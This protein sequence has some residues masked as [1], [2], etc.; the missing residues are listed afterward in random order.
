MHSSLSFM[1]LI[2]TNLTTVLQSIIISMTKHVVEEAIAKTLQSADDV[3]DTLGV[4]D[5]GCGS[6]P[7]TLSVM[8]AI[9]KAV[10]TRCSEIGCRLPELRMSL[11][12]LPDNDFNSVFSVLEPGFYR[13]MMVEK[14]LCFISGVPGSFYGRLFP[15]N[16]LHFVYS[17]SSVHWLSQVR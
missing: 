6:G 2:S 16:S 1:H 17:S 10:H 9:I 3:P 14:E 13:E 7:N 8:S 11:N 5:L 12:D 4:A 15:R